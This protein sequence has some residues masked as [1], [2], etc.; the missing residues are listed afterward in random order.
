MIRKDQYTFTSIETLKSFFKVYLSLDV[1]DN[2]I[3]KCKR[4]F[5]KRPGATIKENRL[6]LI[7][8]CEWVLSRI[9]KRGGGCI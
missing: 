8:K 6:Q 2:T 1:I 3:D 5:I 7:K 4:T 9:L